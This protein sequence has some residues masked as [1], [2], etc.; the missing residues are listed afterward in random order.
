MKK[1]VEL[2]IL[3]VL[4]VVFTQ[5]TR[6]KLSAFFNNKGA[7][8]YN[9]NLYEEAI[10][11]FEKSLKV[12]LSSVAHCNLAHTYMELEQE[13]A[14]IKEYKKSIQ[15]KPEN[16]NAHLALSRIYSNRQMY[17]EA[18]G[19]LKRAKAEFP[20]EIA[21]RKAY[22][23]ITFE[24]MLNYINKGIK[25]YS[26]GD[27]IKAYALLGKALEIGS[28]YT[29]P[30]YFLSY[31]YVADNKYSQA[32]ALLEKV[33]RIKPDFFSAYML[34]GD[35]YY[36][37]GDYEKAISKYKPCLRIDFDNGYLHNNLGLT[38]M[39]M[40]CYSKAIVHL[41]KALEISPNNLI[42]HYNLASFYRDKGLLDKA[43]LEYKKVL[44][45]LP[46]YPH[47]HNDLGDIY[48]QQG[49]KEDA[50]KEYHI[51]IENCRKKLKTSPNSVNTLNSI[52]YAYNKAD[53]PKKAKEII[54]GI[55]KQYP[56][57]RQ[58]YLT[59]AKIEENMGNNSRALVV[60]NKAK[61]LSAYSGFIDKDISRL[62]KILLVKKIVLL[63]KIYLKNGRMMEGT[64]VKETNEKIVLEVYLGK[65]RGTTTLSRDKIKS[66]TRAQTTEM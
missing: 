30:Y 32:E 55:T 46:E 44:K 43:V 28:S 23:E 13:D 35:L 11:Y 29:Q 19:F 12:K 47:I 36:K 9:L 41:E 61:S 14:A 18:F 6:P 31:F 53:K 3:F 40:E 65:S 60:L 59:L 20:A 48:A 56:Y 39:N 34:F 27:K 10:S 45:N 63:D 22:E 57:W 62:K 38:F 17:E 52:A 15:G 26:A 4:L 2:L 16:A 58:A 42:F 33:L 1:I 7:I 50:V 37:K 25:A 24:Y 49:K 64:I 54:K 66:I 8:C 5:A 51:E 21:I